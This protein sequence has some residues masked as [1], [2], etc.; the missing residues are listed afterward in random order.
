MDTNRFA[1]TTF[2][3]LLVATIAPALFFT[4]PV[5]AQTEFCQSGLSYVLDFD[6]DGSGSSLSAGTI[7]GEQ[8]ATKGI[9][10]STTNTSGSDHPM[11]IFDTANPTGNDI[12][13]G[14]PNETC[15]P[16]GPGVGV[17]GEVG[18]TYEN[19]SPLG[20]TLIL[21]TDGD[22]SDPDDWRPSGSQYGVITMEFDQDVQILNIALL[23]T[24]N[25]EDPVEIFFNDA[26]LSSPVTS[27][28]KPGDNGFVETDVSGLS[29]ADVRRMDVK[30]YGSGSFPHIEL[31]YFDNT[32]SV[33]LAAFEVMVAD[34][35]ALLEWVTDSETNNSGFAIEHK[36]GTR[37]FEEIG[38]VPGSGT[39]ANRNTYSFAVNQLSPGL[40]EFRLRQVDYDGSPSYSGVVEAMVEMPGRF[41]LESAYP[42]PFNP[43]TTLRFSVAESMPV[44]LSLHT[45]LGERV[46]L[47]YRGVAPA[48]SSVP[49]TI[50]AAGLPSGVYLV[51]MTGEGIQASQTVTLMK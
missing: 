33:E 19:C 5:L 27:L 43:T 20:N 29:P 4:P 15:S 16:A 49:V 30:M 18:S 2:R 48:G 10:F 13:L 38:F 26:A 12:D 51:R 17:G 28:P 8:W 32:L 34:D 9:H 1:T 45:P 14:A 7:V 3:A 40:H 35:A 23:D 47:L 22:T 50:D 36:S 24:D 21:S 31:C 6:T 11:M 44:E 46:R 39:S 25:D 41:V 37:P 42:N